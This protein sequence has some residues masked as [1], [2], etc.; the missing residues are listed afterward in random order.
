M[1]APADVAI[2]PHEQA[3]RLGCFPQGCP[4]T[5]G[6]SYR[7]A[8]P[9]E[10]CGHRQPKVGRGT[11]RR[12]QPSLSSDAGEHGKASLPH[13]IKGREGLVLLLRPSVGQPGSGASGGQ[14]IQ[15]GVEGRGSGWQ[16]IWHHC[17]GRV[18]VVQLHAVGLELVVLLMRQGLLQGRPLGASQRCRVRTVAAM[19]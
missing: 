15:L 16:A 7:T 18:A 9:D 12:R 8:R 13:Q 3:A 11:G 5:I 19:P 2:G 6:V 1:G 14:L 4:D 17:G 10:V